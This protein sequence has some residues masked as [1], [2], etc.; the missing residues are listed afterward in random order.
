MKTQQGPNQDP[1][2]THHHFEI[3]SLSIPL[4]V[5]W[6]KE[7]LILGETNL[8]SEFSGQVDEKYRVG[9]SK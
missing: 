7:F 2:R 4:T 5:E 8:I 1:A 9:R 6:S 3:Y